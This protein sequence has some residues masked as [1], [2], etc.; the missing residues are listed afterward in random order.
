V[1]GLS[2]ASGLTKP[3]TLRFLDIEE[4]FTPLDAGFSEQAPP[5]AGAR[6]AFSEGL[7][8]W[9]GTKRGK[10]AGRFEG[11]CTFTKVHLAA[12]AVTSYCVATAYLPKG[13][14][15]LGGFIRFVEQGPGGFVIPIMGGTGRYANA[16]GTATFRD[17]PSGNQAVVLRL[18][19]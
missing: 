17:L 16:R 9:A 15:V 1:I 8:E 4:A 2:A 3:E 14:L 5:P 6:F 7:Y 10:R 18:I 13:Q 12:A 11:M 19:P